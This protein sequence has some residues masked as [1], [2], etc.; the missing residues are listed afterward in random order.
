MAYH[1]FPNVLIHCVFGT[2]ERRMLVP[3]EL[4]PKLWRYFNGIGQNIRVPV[5]TAG[6]I[7]NHAHLLIALPPDITLAAS[8]QKLKANSSRWMGE[9]GVKFAWQTGYGAFSVSA[10]NQKAVREYIEHQPEHH[11][12][13]SFEDEFVALLDKSGVKYDRARVFD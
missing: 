3:E 11:A 12:R 2:K 4:Q 8:I 13:R 9:H 1:S 6:G 5:L 7:A 10:S